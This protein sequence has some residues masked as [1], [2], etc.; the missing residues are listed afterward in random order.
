MGHSYIESLALFGRELIKNPG[1]IGAAVPSSPALARGMARMVH[2]A[3][4]GYVVELGAGTGAIT[5]GLIREGVCPERL[6][7]V[8]YSPEMAKLLRRRFP[9]IT[10]LQGDACNLNHLLRQSFGHREPPPIAAVVSSLPLRSLPKRKVARLFLEVRRLL[11]NGGHFIQFTYA[12]HRST[13]FPQCFK[14]IESSLVWANLPPAR[15]E[16]YAVQPPVR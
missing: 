6:M 3:A 13:R 5:E 9:L 10:V 12:V 8:E 4:D 7:A 14:L 16:S 15:V 11:A 1:P 2:G